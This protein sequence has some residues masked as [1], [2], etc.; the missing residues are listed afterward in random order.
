MPE[1]TFNLAEETKKTGSNVLVVSD[2]KK[3]GN[4]TVTNVIIE[5]PS[6]RFFPLMCAPFIE[7]FV[8]EAAKLKGREA[9]IFRHAIK[10][11]SKEKY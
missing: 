7:F 2:N 9:G 4:S 3:Y 1:L 10:I 8:H 6:S 11:T 5:S